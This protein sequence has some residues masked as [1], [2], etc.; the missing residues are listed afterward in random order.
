MSGRSKRKV[1]NWVQSFGHLY[2]N[3]GKEKTQK[4]NL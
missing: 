3:I 4:D 2:I 1:T